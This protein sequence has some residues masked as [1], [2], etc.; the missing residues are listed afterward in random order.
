MKQILI[1]IYLSAWTSLAN[2]QDQ[3]NMK[4]NQ[5]APV[6]ISKAIMINEKPEKIWNTLSGISK[7]PE[8]NSKIKKASLEGGLKQGAEF[9]WVSGGS[10]IKSKIH[11]YHAHKTLGW[12]GKTFGAKAIHNWHFEVLEKG[13]K[14]T[15]EESMEGWLIGL[16]KKK[17]NSMLPEDMTYWLEALKSECEK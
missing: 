10:K 14:V 11:T 7:W 16:L 5:E 6:V 8:W 13:T 9:V 3:T 1:L 2:A 4:I 17:M 12:T 15:V